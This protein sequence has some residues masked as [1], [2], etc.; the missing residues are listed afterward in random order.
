MDAWIRAFRAL[1]KMQRLTLGTILAFSF[2]AIVVF[3]RGPQAQSGTATADRVPLQQALDN[4]QAS[5]T[6]G[7]T[8][9]TG[10]PPPASAPAPSAPAPSTPARIVAQTR[11]KTV[12]T[13]AVY[14]TE[15]AMQQALMAIALARMRNQ[16]DVR[17]RSAFASLI[18]CIP[19]TGSAVEIQ[20]RSRL[21]NPSTA[22]LRVVV[23]DGE[24]SGC[25]GYMDA[26]DVR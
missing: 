15:A 6:L 19:P 23:T 13:T 24:S 11:G 10:E 22:V 17:D 14:R 9:R 1:P 2:A 3:V 26:D 18:A 25:R 16:A 7:H 4:E 12:G 5:P 21:S 20:S 8:R